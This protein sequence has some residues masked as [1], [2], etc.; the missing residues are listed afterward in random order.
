[1]P[2]DSVD[3]LLSSWRKKRPDLDFAPLGIVVRL[4]RLRAHLD[5]ELER[6][7]EAHGLSTAN[8]AVLVTLA[9]IGDGGPVNQKRLMDELGLTSGTISIRMD[10]LV[11]A[12][13]V[14]RLPDPK[15]RRNTLIVLTERGRELFERVAPAHLANERRLLCTLTD[16]EQETLARLLRTMLSEFEGSS[17]PDR[18]QV[19]LGLTVAPAHKS[20]EMRE[21]V[22]LDAFPALL[23]LAVTDRGPADRAGIR[24]GDLL[25]S[26]G[27]HVLRT[28]AA[29]HAS[30]DAAGDARYLSLHL[31]RGTAQVDVEV[32][33]GH[34]PSPRPGECLTRWRTTRG[35][36]VV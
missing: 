23:V 36:H 20:M 16:S 33:L 22:G 17:P 32:E 21:S 29:L 5:R 11:E 26:A 1:M 10:R 12:E 15:S 30:I 18:T 9:R 31:L 13:L 27:S 35:E 4:A 28:V 2:S 6:V 8:F 25:V 3:A 34:A 14:E 7:F 19:R 24:C